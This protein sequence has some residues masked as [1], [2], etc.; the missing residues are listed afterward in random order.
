MPRAARQLSR[1]YKKEID[2]LLSTAR[3]KC[4][5]QGLDIR[6]APKGGECARILVIT[7]RKSG[8]APQRNK[9][10]RRIKALF[11]EEKLYQGDQ[12]WIIFVKKEA[13]QHDFQQLK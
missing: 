6:L 1:F 9:I 11:Y 5:Y 10:R 12:D 8:N 13:Q 3:R 2:L 4:R 7:P